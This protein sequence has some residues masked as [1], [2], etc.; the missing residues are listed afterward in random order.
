MEGKA[1]GVDAVV[2]AAGSKALMNGGLVTLTGAPRA[3]G[4]VK[5]VSLDGTGQ[6]KTLMLGSY[7]AA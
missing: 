2:V 6:T 5:R 7:I 1:V 4:V 3:I